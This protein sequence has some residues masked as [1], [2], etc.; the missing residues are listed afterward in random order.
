MATEAAPSKAHVNEVLGHRRMRSMTMSK[1]NSM[2]EPDVPLAEDN[3]V[4]PIRRL[5]R[6]NSLT[7]VRE[8]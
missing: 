3:S 5:R 1:S 7:N 4:Q 6:S 8:L 2:T